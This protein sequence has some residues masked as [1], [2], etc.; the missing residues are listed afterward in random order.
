MSKGEELL[1]GI[2]NVK[3]ELVHMGIESVTKQDAVEK[4]IKECE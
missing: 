1:H 2:S 4:D 3:D